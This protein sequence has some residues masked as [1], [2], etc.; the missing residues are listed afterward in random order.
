MVTAGLTATLRLVDR[1]ERP[2]VLTITVLI[3][4]ISLDLRRARVDRR[5]QIGTIEAGAVDVFG[6]DPVA[7]DVAACIGAQAEVAGVGLPVVIGVQRVVAQGTYV[8]I[9]ADRSLTS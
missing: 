8:T 1:L 4:A 6:A 9:I 3:Q 7:V 2:G 5:V